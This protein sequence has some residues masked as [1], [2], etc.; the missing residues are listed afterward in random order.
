MFDLN[1]I[2]ANTGAEWSRKGDIFHTETV[3]ADNSGKVTLSYAPV[4]VQTGGKAYL[5]YR[6]ATEAGAEYSKIVA[7]GKVVNLGA[8]FIDAELCVMY[9]YTNNFADQIII[10]SQ[11]I[12]ETLHAV[13]TVALYAGDSCNIGETTNKIGEVTIDIPRFQ[14]SGSQEISMTSAGASQTALDGNALASGCTGCDG[15][16]IYATITK[17]LFDQKAS[18]LEEVVIEDGNFELVVGEKK[19]MNCY[20]IFAGSVPHIMDKSMVTWSSA[21]PGVA[22]CEGN[23][24]TAVAAGSSVIKA[25]VVVE[26]ITKI[27]SATCKVV[28]A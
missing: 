12:P 17:V 5:Y 19:E 3:V 14:L 13:L 24:I 25:T 22:E 1:Y 27:A 11:F 9:R 6:K 18:A 15:K 21:T 10:S 2:A 28:S 20:A 7:D 16:A 4:A 8:D 26:G 23:V